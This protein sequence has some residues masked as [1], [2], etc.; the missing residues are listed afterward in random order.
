VQES[1]WPSVGDEL[2]PLTKQFERSQLVV[3]AAGSGDFNPLHFDPNWPQARVIG[4]NIVHGRL[5]YASLG[6]LVSNWLGH[7]GSVRRIAASYRGMDYCGQ[8]LTCRG[9]VTAIS[10]DEGQRVVDLE[11]WTENASGER[12]TVGAAEVV[13]TAPPSDM[14]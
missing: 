2:P 3:F 8:Q 1:T 4:D 12:T 10:D 9:R 13:L 14:T 5:K 6:Q 11:L 7:R